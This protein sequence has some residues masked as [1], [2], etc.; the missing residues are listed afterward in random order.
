MFQVLY[1]TNHVSGLVWHKSCFRSAGEDNG[2]ERI[3]VER[4]SWSRE[5]HGRERI[6]IERGGLGKLARYVHLVAVAGAEK[7]EPFSSPHKTVCTLD[8]CSIREWLCLRLGL[9]L[10]LCLKSTYILS[11]K[12]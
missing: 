9:G 3:M 2:R 1:S 6:M 12:S 5:D 7:P 10:A 8:F 11:W 4:G